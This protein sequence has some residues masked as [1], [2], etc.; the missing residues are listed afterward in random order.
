M[1]VSETQ[2]QDQTGPQADLKSL[3]LPQLEAKLATSA[4]G[5]TQAEAD[6]RLTRYGPNALAEKKVSPLLKFLGYFWGPIPWMIEAAAVLSAVVQHWSDL[7]IILVL[8][9]A[10]AV[11]GFW[12]EFQAG[13]A[14]AALKARLAPHARVK[15]DGAWTDLA[16]RLLVPGDIVRLRL[17]DIVPADARSLGPDPVE[18][19]QAA[20][21]GESLPVSRGTGEVLFS[22]AI[23]RQGETDALVYATGGNTFFGKTAPWCSRPTRP[24]TSSARC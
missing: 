20:L 12:E 10:N 5:L 14:I 11:V 4:N 15:R 6:R 9:F 22:G 1:A 19:D 2:P 24:A 23:L 7:I 17:G 21:T 3:P 13:N 16:A 18:V 8:L